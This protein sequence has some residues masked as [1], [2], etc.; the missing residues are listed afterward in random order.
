M[1]TDTIGARIRYWRRRR[2]GMTQETLAGLAGVTQSYISQV[3]SGRHVVDRRSTLARIAAALQITTA[4]LLGQPDP[5]DPAATGG[6]EQ[7]PTIWARLVEIE[8]GERGRPAW[9]VEHLGAVLAEGR[10]LR[11]RAEHLQL[12]ALLPDLLPEAAA[13]GGEPL[14][15]AAYLAS[16][17]LRHLGYR[18]L[19]LTAARVAATAAEEIEDPAWLGMARMG[20]VLAL[21]PEAAGLTSRLADRS[22]SA[23]QAAA[24]QPDV[25]QV[26]GQLH[27]GAAL[28]S[29]VDGR[30]DD[31]AAHLA[32]ASREADSLGDPQDGF[33]FYG[34]SFGP[35][36]VALWRMA[37]ANELGEYGRAVE[38]AAT[39][40]PDKLRAANRHLAYHLDLAK[41]LAHVGRR[42]GEALAALLTAERAAPTLFSLHPIARESVTAMVRRAQYRAVPDTLRVLARRVGVDA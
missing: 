16:T 41:G 4:D 35:S 26:L 19:A 39:F 27:L 15:Q 6:A 30:G 33:G 13:H 32:E 31:S 29:A 7:V 20:H 11:D 40:R 8:E 34:C 2:N 3:E 36:N 18:H 1:N 25:R 10:I 24:A 38:L 42:D 21:P 37:I 23:L 22:L 14:V 12:A 5:A 28:A 17:C 9:P